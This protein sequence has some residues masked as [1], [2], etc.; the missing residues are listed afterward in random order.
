MTGNGLNS[1]YG[2]DIG[3]SELVRVD[4]FKYTIGRRTLD[5]HGVKHGLSLFVIDLSDLCQLTVHMLNEIG[6]RQRET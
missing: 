1:S 2:R 6:I 4:P 3:I 5:E